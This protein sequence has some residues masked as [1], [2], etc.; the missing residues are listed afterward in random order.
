MPETVALAAMALGAGVLGTVVVAWMF[1]RM[2]A[3]SRVA[4]M[5]Q[6]RGSYARVTAEHMRVMTD[7]TVTT[8]PGPAIRAAI[9]GPATSSAPSSTSLALPGAPRWLLPVV[10]GP[11]SV[12]AGPA[13][14]RPELAVRA[15]RRVDAWLTV[16]A[17]KWRWYQRLDLMLTVAE[18]HIR[19]HSARPVTARVAVPDHRHVSSRWLVDTLR[20]ERPTGQLTVPGSYAVPGASGAHAAGVAPGTRAQR[21]P[22][23]VADQLAAARAVHGRPRLALTAEAG[24]GGGHEDASDP[25]P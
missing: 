3:A 8:L 16:R 5:A 7:Q 12:L 23:R 22:E 21:H 24:T 18:E 13:E 11:D 14:P 1:G 2:R 9:A 19:E 15:L 6:A 10:V 20:A 17:A 4:R 25:T